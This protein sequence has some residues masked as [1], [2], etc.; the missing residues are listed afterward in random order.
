[1][2][3][4]RP[5]ALLLAGL[6]LAACSPLP[7]LPSKPQAMHLLTLEASPPPAPAAPRLPHTLLLAHVDAVPTLRSPDL[8][9]RRGGPVV[10]RYAFHRWVTTPAELLD[11][12]L[13]ETLAP[14]L[15]YAGVVLPEQGLPAGRAL[16]LTLLRLEQDFEDDRHSQLRLAVRA[17]LIDLDHDRILATRHFHYRVPTPEASPLGAARAAGQAVS[18]LLRD[19]PPWLLAAEGGTS[20]AAPP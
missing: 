13:V 6:L 15:P 19:L 3:A 18:R 17:E 12:V 20:A 9:Y 11:Q 10:H 4:R 14:R 2:N 1:M 7:S 8:L 5:L 16:S